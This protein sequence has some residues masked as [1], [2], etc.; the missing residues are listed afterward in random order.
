MKSLIAV[1]VLFFASLNA[2]ACQPEDFAADVVLW[3]ESAFAGVVLS[4]CPHDA[5]LTIRVRIVSRHFAPVGTTTIV[6]RVPAGE[7]AVFEGQFPPK[8]M[9]YA[10]AQNSQTRVLNCREARR[11]IEAADDT[12]APIRNADFADLVDAGG[13]IGS[14]R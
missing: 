13:L 3:G 6:A 11:D 1:V 4:R 5:E 10:V 9:A 2:F 14:Q 7:A 12:A 8:K